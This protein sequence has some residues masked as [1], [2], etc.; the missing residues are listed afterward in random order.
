MIPFPW[1]VHDWL[2][3]VHLQGDFKSFF[4]NLAKLVLLILPQ[5]GHMLSQADITIHLEN[6]NDQ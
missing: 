5:E 2:R 4:Q 1:L 3:L 6:S